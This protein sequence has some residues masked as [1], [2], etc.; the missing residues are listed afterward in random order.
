MGHEEP[1][2]GVGDH[3]WG[4]AVL[5]AFT[6]EAFRYTF[7]VGHRWSAK[8]CV[9]VKVVRKGRADAWFWVCI[10]AKKKQ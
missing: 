8:V 3:P 5:T 1:E 10:P 4:A 6:T 7:Q 2:D 9:P